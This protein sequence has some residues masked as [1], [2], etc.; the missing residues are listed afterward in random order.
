MLAFRDT[1]SN[2]DTLVATFESSKKLRVLDA[3]KFGAYYRNPARVNEQ[4]INT[5]T[6]NPRILKVNSALG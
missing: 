3:A 2:I 4:I 5:A 6:V 1:T